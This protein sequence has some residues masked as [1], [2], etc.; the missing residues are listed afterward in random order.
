MKL[1]FDN[2]GSSCYVV[3]V[4]N[5]DANPEPG[6]FKKGLDAIRKVDR[7]RNLGAAKPA[8]D[9]RHTGKVITELV[10]SGAMIVLPRMSGRV[11]I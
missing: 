5:Y 9:D 2:G 3:S 1:F 6:H 4:G 11:T 10:E 7:V 8:V